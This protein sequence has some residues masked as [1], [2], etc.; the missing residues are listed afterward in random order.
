MRGKGR[1]TATS[2]WGEAG[3]VGCVCCQHPA[4]TA[5][6]P[7]AGA[8]PCIPAGPAQP[9]ADLRNRDGATQHPAPSPLALHLPWPVAQS[10]VLVKMRKYLY[11]N[12]LKNMVCQIIKAREHPRSLQLDWESRCC[13]PMLR[14]NAGGARGQPQPCVMPDLPMWLHNR[15]EVFIKTG[16]GLAFTC[17]NPAA[18]CRS[19]NQ[20]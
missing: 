14:C 5:P 16:G 17:I 8:L 12:N 3:V 6:G 1:I 13:F 15:F 10:M 7:Q 4:R 18:C 19:L 11:K 20:G 2:G 9:P